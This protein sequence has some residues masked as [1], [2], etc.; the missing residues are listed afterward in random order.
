MI[1]SEGD[2]VYCYPNTDVL[3]NKLNITNSE[4]LQEAERMI[5]SINM[6]EL[7]EKP[8]KGKYDLH[9]LQ[10]IHKYI[11]DD[12]YAWAGKLR[13]VNIAKG[14]MFCNYMFIQNCA[15]ELFRN[16]RK[17]HYLQG[18]DLE[19]FAIRAAYYFS[20]INAIHPFREGNG[21]TQREFF[22]SLALEA[23]YAI[24][25]SEVSE[26]E[27]LEASIDSFAGNYQKMQVL[28]KNHIDPK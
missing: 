16:L 18:L 1:Y 10:M 13:T 28:F 8:I 5:T 9:H 26:S 2:R 12:L 6:L 19:T 25:F 15:D 4:R 3:I 21:R 27:M 22:R 20:E 17:E 14:N 23:G 11:F 24:R 7:I